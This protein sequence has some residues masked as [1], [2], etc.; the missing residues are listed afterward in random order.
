MQ[1]EKACDAMGGLRR[2]SVNSNCVPAPKLCHASV[3]A[4]NSAF[5]SGQ[6][7]FLSRFGNYL[8]TT[9]TK[10]DA[11][12]PPKPADAPYPCP[13]CGSTHFHMATF[14]Q[15]VVYPGGGYQ[16]QSE[17]REA[18]VCLCGRPISTEKLNPRYEKDRTF[19]GSLKLAEKYWEQAGPDQL[20][21]EL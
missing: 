1:C 2:L 8:P 12:M 11:M 10:S 21:E 6:L 5:M 14:A 3:S 13:R 4:A 16:I 20:M 19:L 17:P 18:V 15:Y 7:W 9:N